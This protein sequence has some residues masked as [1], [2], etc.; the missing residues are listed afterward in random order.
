MSIALACRPMEA[1]HAQEWRGHCLVNLERMK[2]L[3][4]E[5]EREGEEGGGG[6]RET[7]EHGRAL[8]SHWEYPTPGW[9]L[10]GIRFR[11]KIPAKSALCGGRV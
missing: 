10:A 7:R 3:R 8:F 1:K 5:S 11:Q 4:N 6:G 2:D 9:E